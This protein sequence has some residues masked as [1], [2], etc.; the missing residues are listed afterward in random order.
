[1]EKIVSAYSAFI[2]R[3]W[4]P[5]ADLIKEGSKLLAYAA[6]HGY[7]MSSAYDELFSESINNKLDVGKRIYQHILDVAFREHIKLNYN[8]KKAIQ[9]YV[10][11]GDY[12]GYKN[13]LTNS[14]IDNNA[15]RTAFS[16]IPIEKSREV[17]REAI[18]TDP[19]AEEIITAVFA[20]AFY[21]SFDKKCCDLYFSGQQ[22][23]DERYDDLLNRIY[24]GFSERQLSQFF[25]EIDPEYVV[26]NYEDACNYY[27]NVI[28]TAYERLD[29]YTDLILVIPSIKLGQVDLQWKLYADLILFAEKHVYH[30]I[31]RMYFRHKKIAA[32]T[33]EYID[34]LDEQ[35][36]E[37]E[38]AAEGFV[39]KDC[40]VVHSSKKPDYELVLVFE[41]DYRDERLIN[42]PA[43]RSNRVQGNSYPILNV[44]SWE[45]DNALC[46]DRSKY[47]RGKR[48]SYISYQ[49][50]EAME[51]EANEI[52]ECSLAEWHLDCVRDKTISEIF[53]MACRFYSF[54]GDTVCV[55]SKSLKVGKTYKGRNIIATIDVNSKNLFEAF[56]K[57]PYFKRYD[58]PN[59]NSI[60]VD[61]SK[62][63]YELSPINKLYW[64]DSRIILHALEPE[65]ITA[66]VTSPPYYNAKAYSQW[67][68][69]YC[70]LYDMRNIAL[71]VYRV[72]RPGGVY[73]FNIFDYFDNEKNIV[74][75]AMGDKRMILGAYVIELFERIGFSVYGNI[76]WDKGEIQGNRNFNQ[77]N[78]TPYY[79]APLNCWEH[80]IVFSKG[81]INSKFASLVSCVKQIR[82]F[83][84]YKNGKN[85][86][87]HDAPFPEEIP[88]IL[89]NCM[90][91]DD[92]VLDPFSGSYTTGIAAYKKNIRSVSIEKSE[93]YINLS[94]KRFN[95][96]VYQQLTLE[97]L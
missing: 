20:R 36:A 52:D 90:S 54:V 88:D 28:S 73:L 57:S 23:W 72:L 81:E 93:E 87:G 30:K 13:F 25:V 37:F 48:Y 59:N 51:N 43:C 97:G 66:A 6:E 9:D 42:C 64:G 22:D 29:N 45:C 82:P 8:L 53:D 55:L 77:G 63:E 61:L 38:L 1:M 39:F 58:Y 10:T 86:L 50:Q 69:I 11:K 31:D 80:V 62:V 44:R 75:S 71:E 68:N 32:A 96:N 7:L 16:V 70:Y 67:D 91:G 3:Q 79:Q 60:T 94:K 17:M 47:N 18:S 95:E 85:T 33:K 34:N 78:M 24:E 14:G 35:N 65:S 15:L 83:I 74:L 26:K 21:N 49:R 4:S 5:P 27:Y 46:P 41:K 84:K 12:T 19:R 92:V 40:F 56:K 2:G 89:L 76:I